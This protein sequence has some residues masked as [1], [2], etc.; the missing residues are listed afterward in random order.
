MCAEARSNGSGARNLDRAS[1]VIERSHTAAAPLHTLV[2]SLV[3]AA[4]LA[5]VGG[6]GDRF[7]TPPISCCCCREARAVGRLLVRSIG[8]PFH[9]PSL[10]PP[11]PRSR[12]TIARRRP[13]LKSQQ[14]ALLAADRWPDRCSRARRVF[15][16]FRRFEQRAARLARS[17]VL[18]L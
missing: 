3:Y 11:P 13:P 12:A 18:R 7:T 15:A 10:S 17:P 5:K 14:R 2:R 8:R 16:S 6:R 9:S 1:V 4:R